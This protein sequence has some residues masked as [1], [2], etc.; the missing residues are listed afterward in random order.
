MLPYPL[1]YWFSGQGSQGA[2]PVVLA[3]PGMQGPVGSVGPS[4][5]GGSEGRVIVSRVHSSVAML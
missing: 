5:T 3:D 4:V 2:L 1:A